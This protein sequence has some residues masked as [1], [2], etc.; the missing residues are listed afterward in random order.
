MP[1]TERHITVGHA[2]TVGN[3]TRSTADRTASFAVMRVRHST[4]RKERRLP[5][6]AGQKNRAD[7]IQSR[8]RCVEEMAVRRAYYHP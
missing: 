5:Y 2:L 7:E 8:R 4:A 6:D 3:P 1:K